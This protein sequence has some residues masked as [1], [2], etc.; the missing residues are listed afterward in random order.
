MRAGGEDTESAR[1]LELPAPLIGAVDFYEEDRHIA[2]PPAGQ[3]PAG[4]GD[5]QAQA[6]ERVLKVINDVL[7]VLG[8][9][10]DVVEVGLDFPV[11]I[12]GKRLSA[13]Q[14]QKLDLARAL[15]KR[16]D[17]LLLNQSTSLLDSAAQ[18]KV[19]A[20]FQEPRRP[21]ASG[22]IPCRHGH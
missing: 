11:G 21:G 14:R 7:G 5:G 10:R 4:S 2:P 18:A 19:M 6:A 3:H 16:P 12:G 20:I 15:V 17:L 1:G 8:L 13:A 22:F 9:R